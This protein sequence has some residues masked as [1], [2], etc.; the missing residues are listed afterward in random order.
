MLTVT[1]TY[2][3]ITL[4]FIPL[5]QSA[6]SDDPVDLN[7]ATISQLDALPYVSSSAAQLI[8]NLRPIC[9]PLE[10]TTSPKKISGITEN[11]LNNNWNWYSDQ[12]CDDTCCKAIASCSSSSSTNTEATYTW[13]IS[14]W[15]ECTAECGTGQQTRTVT[16]YNSTKTVDDSLCL[17]LTDGVKPAIKQ[18]CNTQNCPSYEW[19]AGEWSSCDT[20]S[21]TQTRTVSCYDT[22][23]NTE[24]TDDK[25]DSS[26]KS[27][28]T[29]SCETCTRISSANTIKESDDDISVTID[30]LHDYNKQQCKTQLYN[31]GEV[32]D[33][34]LITRRSCSID[35]WVVLNGKTNSDAIEKSWFYLNATL[36]GNVN[37]SVGDTW[38]D[39][40]LSW[41]AY[42]TTTGWITI[43][44]PAD[45]YIG[46]Y[47]SSLYYQDNGQAANRKKVTDFTLF[48]L[49]NPYSSSDDVY[50]SS[51]T[52]RKEYVENTAG[53]IWQGL[54]D[55]NSG[56]KWEF[57]QFNIQNL[58]ISIK[59][60]N[61]LMLQYRNDIVLISRQI[62]YAVGAD[63]CY[64]KWGD[65]SYTTGRPSGGY[66]CSKTKNNC[67]DPSSWRGTT[68]LFDL[69]RDELEYEYPVQYCQCFVYSGVVTTVGRSLGIPTR[70]I[71]N[72]QSAHDTDFNRAIEKYWIF[73]EE[74]KV[75]EPSKDG[76]SSDSI[77][78]FV[79]FIF[80][81][82][83]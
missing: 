60:L 55:N 19:V 28:T 75:Y 36:I 73:N 47:I 79:K 23:S 54:S 45:G 21:C 8:I 77:W 24:E 18:L 2:F 7:T 17:T 63:I 65:G 66:Y 74:T 22:T 20:N 82:D 40:Y 52:N 53:L 43:T 58:E 11:R 71:S 64:G 59:L 32:I 26:D 70:S 5:T 31:N 10:L 14:S 48:V 38:N 3:I 46:K 83:I 15:S 62:S 44:F 1:T 69:Y 72:F 4:C 80:C 35:I 30:L 41:Y 51:T 6:C 12:S 42:N 50:V 68:E 76:K 16:C 33:K 13:Q 27:D 9:S 67:R 49:F 34:T 78:S 61:R 37:E 56:F 25:C 39:N 57:D 29:Q 81:F